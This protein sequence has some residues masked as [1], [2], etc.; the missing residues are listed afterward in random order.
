ME[1]FD[2]LVDTYAQLLRD[3]GMRVL[4][5]KPSGVRE[6]SRQ[7]GGSMIGPPVSVIDRLR[8]KVLRP[9]YRG[10]L[11]LTAARACRAE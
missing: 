3:H 6:R 8:R 4:S 5:V 7:L 2:R 10:K 9:L 11:H 1:R